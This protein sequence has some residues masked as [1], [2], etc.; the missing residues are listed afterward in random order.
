MPLSSLRPTTPASRHL[1]RFGVSLPI[2]CILRRMNEEVRA[3]VE[4]GCIH[5]RLRFP[6]LQREDRIGLA[7]RVGRTTPVGVDFVVMMT[8]ASVL[9]SR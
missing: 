4:P 7:E 8:L 6:L 5:R 3:S 9:A 1:L 2:R